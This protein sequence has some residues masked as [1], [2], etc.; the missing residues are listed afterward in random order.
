MSTEPY[1]I[2]VHQHVLP[3]EY[4]SALAR[5]GITGGGGRPF[6][7]W[8]VKSTL[9]LMDRHGIVTAI[10]S[11]SEPGVYFSD[12]AF[13][14]DLARRCNEYAARLVQ[15]Y[16]ARFGAFAVLPLP[17]IDAAL[18][19][20]EYAL[21][22]LKLD[23]V[24]LLSSIEGTYPGDPAFDELFAELNRRRAVVFL[25]PTVPAINAGLKLNLPPFL[26]EFALDTTRA[27]A[28]LL[29]S[30][31]LARCPAIRF[32]LAHAGGIVPYLAY[33]IP[34]YQETLPGALQGV[35]NYLQQFYYDTAL[36]ATPRV[37]RA[38]QELVDASHI[39][40]GSDYPFAPETVTAFSVQG[41]QNYDGFDEQAR[42]AVERENALALFPRF[43]ALK[44]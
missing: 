26:F 40:F 11:L 7:A 38:L 12:R 20:L 36:S 29:F 21:D 28:N 10:T 32:I 16:P 5:L 25:H 22:T 23:G 15:E 44:E 6:P 9:E 39:L 4:V 14:R 3:P 43:N 35:M 33:R 42:R 31:T 13:A 1:R 17:D 8:D 30:G 24:I 41:I 18:R 34:L 37:L 2:D 19:E 27:A